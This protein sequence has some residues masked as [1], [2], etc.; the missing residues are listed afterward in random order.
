MMAQEQGAGE[1]PRYDVRIIRPELRAEHFKLRG[2]GVPRE[3]LRKIKKALR[4]L[5]TLETMAVN[6][7]KFQLTRRR[8][9]LNRQL[10]TAMC[11]EMTHLQ[12]FQVKLYEYGWTP[13][14]FRWAYW[15]VGWV[16]G[17]FSRLLG[18]TRILRTGIWVETKAV[19]HYAELLETVDWDDE[20]RRIV[21]KNQADEGGHISR[22]RTLLEARQAGKAA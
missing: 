22:W 11:N 17:T 12:D 19:D 18:V 4:T 9:D 20:T 3:R 2:E 21:E 8:T 7:Y 16:F 14:R 10:V 6:I 1:A 5:H 13:S 15:I